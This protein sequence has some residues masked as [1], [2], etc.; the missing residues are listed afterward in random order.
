MSDQPST[1][2]QRLFS[3]NIQ[4]TLGQRRS[5]N[6]RQPLFCF[7]HVRLHLCRPFVMLH[8][9]SFI[10]CVVMCPV[11]ADCD[12]C[13][14]GAYVLMNRQPTRCKSSIMGH[15]GRALPNE[16]TIRMHHAN[17][18]NYNTDFDGDPS[19]LEVEN[20]TPLFPFS[21]PPLKPVIFCMR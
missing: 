18:N 10:L 2:P 12:L 9:R 15:K 3:D 14:L 13:V 21:Y 20:P 7:Q 8:G 16:R 17:C 5:S 19:S 11:S 4:P 1:H 6:I